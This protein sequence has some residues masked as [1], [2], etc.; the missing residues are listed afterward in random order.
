M[1]AVDSRDDDSQLV[2]INLNLAAVL[3]NPFRKTQWH[4]AFGIDPANDRHQGSGAF[5]MLKV[6][7]VESSGSSVRLRVEGRL[8]GHCIEELRESCGLHA[9][10]EGLHLTLDMTDVSFADAD[11]ID[12]LRDFR[13]RDV[14]ILNLVPYLALQLRVAEGKAVPLR[15]ND[16]TPEGR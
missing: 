5:K 9:L 10:A 11:G 6:T 12:L 13:S 14:T 4:Q 7:V 15:N 8:T 3:R 16:D 1:Q 2:C